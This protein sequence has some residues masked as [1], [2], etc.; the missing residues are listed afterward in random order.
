M[1]CTS[2]L[3]CC[4]SHVTTYLSQQSCQTTRVIGHVTRSRDHQGHVTTLPGRPSFHFTGTT[5]QL[6]FYWQ[7]AIPL[8]SCF[9]IGK[10][11]FHWQVAFPIGS[12]HWSEV[13]RAR[14]MLRAFSGISG[15]SVL[16]KLKDES[17]SVTSRSAHCCSSG[18]CHIPTHTHTAIHT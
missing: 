14:D 9:S 16:T 18:T 3:S 4:Q 8:A 7:V 11:L 2:K 15:I 6:S 10:L 12:C 1:Y 13:L 5:H 17:V